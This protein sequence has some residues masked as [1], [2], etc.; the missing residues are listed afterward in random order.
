MFIRNNKRAIV[1]CLQAGLGGAVASILA[2][3]MLFPQT[4]FG[5]IHIIAGMLI[6]FFVAMFTYANRKSINELS[7]EHTEK[8]LITLRNLL[9]KRK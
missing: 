9:F 6:A 2:V 8:N 1:F 5:V 7:E 3:L 4:P